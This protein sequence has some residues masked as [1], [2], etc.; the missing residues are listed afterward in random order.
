MNEHYRANLLQ[1]LH[2]ID[3]MFKGEV[4][5]DIFGL[6]QV[7]MHIDTALDDEIGYQGPERRLQ[8]R[9]SGANVEHEIA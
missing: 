1:A 5:L 4:P 3:M 8:P 2:I 7:R 6:Q 9:V